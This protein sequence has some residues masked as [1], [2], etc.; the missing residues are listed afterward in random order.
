M[1]V[2]IIDID[3]D[4]EHPNHMKD[5]QKMLTESN[6]PYDVTIYGSDDGYYKTTFLYY[7]GKGVIRS[8]IVVIENVKNLTKINVLRWTG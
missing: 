6:I 4:Y 1:S 7:P 5:L 3:K 8:S 2:R